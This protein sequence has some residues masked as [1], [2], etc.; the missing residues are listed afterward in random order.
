[1]MQIGHNKYN[2]WR[3]YESAECV[4]VVSSN[5]M[6]PLRRQAISGTNA[7][8]LSIGPLAPFLSTWINCNLH[9]DK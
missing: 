3:I 7:D 8:L 5:D 4:I 1:M 9:M 6:S 2:Q